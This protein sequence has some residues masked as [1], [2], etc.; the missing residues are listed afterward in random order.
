MRKLLLCAAFIILAGC[1]QATT[2]PVGETVRPTMDRS[3][4][5]QQIQVVVHPSYAD[6][7]RAYVK[8]K[9]SAQPEVLGWAAWSIDVPGQC[10][11]HVTK[12]VALKTPVVHTWGH[13]LMHC[14]YGS[15]HTE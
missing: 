9:K 5:I 12:P 10:E 2:P 13:E 8:F 15:Y 3:G 6:L 11:I 4:Q 1:Q 14:V 7:N